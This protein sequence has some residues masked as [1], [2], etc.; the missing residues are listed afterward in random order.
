MHR[1]PG[2]IAEAAIDAGTAEPV[3]L[4]TD[5]SWTCRP[6]LAYAAVTGWKMA[7]LLG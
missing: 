4:A 3:V 5:A 7:M 1:I 6:A 2:L